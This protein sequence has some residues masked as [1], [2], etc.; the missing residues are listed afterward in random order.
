VTETVTYSTLFLTLLLMVGLFFFIRASTKDRTE[1]FS[2]RQAL[3]PE[4]MGAWLME[5]FQG[6]AYEPEAMDTPANADPKEIVLQ[7]IVRPSLFLAGFL[8]FLAA[9]GA[10]CFALVLAILWPAYGVAFMGLVAL[11]PAAGVFYWQRAGRQEV[12]RFRVEAIPPPATPEHGSQMTVTAHRDE[13]IA[14]QQALAKL[15]E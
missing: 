6:R 8:T 5:H 12:V 1:S 3:S 9:I 7:G 2:T 4:A 10:L 15:P 14:L 13:L 11:A